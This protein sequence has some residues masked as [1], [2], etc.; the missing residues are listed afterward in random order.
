[1]DQTEAL[2]AIDVNTGKFV[3]HTSLPETV[4]KTNLE[5]VK[6]IA[7]QLRLRNIG[8]IIIV[9]F[10]DME[11]TEA[12]KQVLAALEDQLKRDK[13][14]ASVLG[15][16]KLGLVEMTRKKERRSLESVF[17]KACPYCEGKGKVLSEQAVGLRV[18]REIYR[19]LAQQPVA[20]L[21]VEAHPSVAAML[22]GPGGKSLRVLEEKTSI[23]IQVRGMESLHSRDF[24]I[25]PLTSHEELWAAAVPVKLGQ[26]L[27]ITVE[28]QHL[29]KPQDAVA[30]VE[31]FVIDIEDGADH[32]GQSVELEITKVLRTYAKAR[33]RRET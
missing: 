3:G 21:L 24:T 33:I 5:A 7:R 30:R 20:A 28:E 12:K 18:R 32:V 6:E 15:L 29:S 23:P 11:D 22:I 9:D 26:V 16:T 19:L 27:T 31:G 13:V 14:K 1:V 4:L 10:I 25:T 17:L 2:T 8:G